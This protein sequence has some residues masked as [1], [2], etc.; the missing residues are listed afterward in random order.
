MADRPAILG[1]TPIFSSELRLVQP[2]LPSLAKIDAQL[3]E[4]LRTGMISN[5]SKYTQEF[6][7]AAANYVNAPKAITVANGTTGLLLLLKAL[8]LKGEVIVPSFT[9]VPT[10]AAIVWNGLTPVF[11]DINPQTF[12]LDPVSVEQSI[13]DRT[14]AILAVHVFGNPCGIATLSEIAGKHKVELV[15]DA[16]HALGAEYHSRKVGCFGTAEVFSLSATKLVPAGEGGVITTD[17]EELAG[18]IA[19]ARDYGCINTGDCEIAGLNG[20]ML[21]FSA[22]LAL[23]ALERLEQHV[24]HRNRVA[25]V[26]AEALE[27]VP[28]L[29]FQRI[30]RNTRS[31][32]KDLAMVVRE[33]E[34]GLTRDEVSRSLRAEG[35]EAR[36]YFFPPIHW[37]TAFRM[38]S[39]SDPRE[40]EHTDYVSTHVLSVPISSTMAEETLRKIAEAIQRIHRHARRIRESLRHDCEA[41]SQV[42]AWTK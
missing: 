15:F 32:Y 39:S 40:L 23:W 5:F 8:G 37:M 6:E 24:M 38:Y 18:K 22:I 9:F 35:I 25:E 36:A 41:Q 1:G 17:C 33:A 12:N 34:F 27:D 31:T 3:E 16:A 7:T 2:T 21:E 26:F 13:T 28:G 14:S 30:D 42:Y 10:V 11:A 4:I 29:E 20:K 19:S